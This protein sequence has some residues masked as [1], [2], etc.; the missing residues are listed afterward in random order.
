MDRKVFLSLHTDLWEP[1]VFLDN[2]KSQNFESTR[3]CTK[4]KLIESGK[5]LLSHKTCIS[6]ATKLWNQLPV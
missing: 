6:D 5:C 1:Y 4:G 3:A 2:K